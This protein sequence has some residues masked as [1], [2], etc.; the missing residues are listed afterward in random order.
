MII[1]SLVLLGLIAFVFW[2]LVYTWFKNLKL[3]V[4]VLVPIIGGLAS[5]LMRP[6]L[7]SF[8]CYLNI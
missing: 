6:T 5:L 3:W 1:L 2:G 8:G 7:I 4:R